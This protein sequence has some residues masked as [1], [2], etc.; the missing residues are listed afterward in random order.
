MSG[1]I[2]YPVNLTSWQ[3]FC[4]LTTATKPGFSLASFELAFLN[5][6]RR[7]LFQQN[8]ISIDWHR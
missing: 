4:F 8:K 5:D 7:L 2:C 3:T 6:S 1:L